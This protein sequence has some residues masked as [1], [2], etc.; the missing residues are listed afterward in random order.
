MFP[1]SNCEPVV[2]RHGNWIRPIPEAQTGATGAVVYGRSAATTNRQGVRM[3]TSELY[4]AVEVLRVTLQ[5]SGTRKKG[6]F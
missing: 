5:R 1:G 3:G 6:G 4:R 2:W